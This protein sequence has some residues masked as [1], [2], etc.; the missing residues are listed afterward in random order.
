MPRITHEQVMEIFRILR[1]IRGRA[2]FFFKNFKY[3]LSMDGLIRARDKNFNVVEWSRAFGSKAPHEVL[4][5]LE[6]ERVEVQLKKQPEPI[7]F[8][9]MPEFLDWLGSKKGKSL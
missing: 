6:V 5:S 8:S 9:S 1:M 3:I 7:V 4:N 2:Y